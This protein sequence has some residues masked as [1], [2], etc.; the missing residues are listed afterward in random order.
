MKKIKYF[1]F[2]ILSITS[3]V[4][5]NDYLDVNENINRVHSEDIPPDLL[6]PGAASQ[7]FR[8]QAITMNGFG[9]LMMNSW[10]GNSYVYGSPFV[11]ETTLASVDNTFYNGIWD[12]LYR[13]VANF[14]AI[15]KFPNSAH[16]YDDYVAAAKVMKAFYMSTIVDMY[17]DCPYTEA[18]KYQAN[19]TPKYDNDED[20]YKSLITELETSVSLMS[21][22]N[23]SALNMEANDIIFQGNRTKWIEFANT[24]KLRMLLRMSKLTGANGT[25]RDQKL[26]TLV[27]KPFLSADVFINPGYSSA[28]D[29]Q[30]NPFYGSFVR[31]STGGKV[32]QAYIASRHISLCLNGNDD[33][34]GN[35]STE[36]VHVKFTGLIDPRRGRMFSL[37]TGGKVRGTNQGANGGQFGTPSSPTT[38][39]THG[40][41][42]TGAVGATV[43]QVVATGSARPGVLMSKA[44][45]DFIQAEIGLKY[46]TV[47]TNPDVKFKDGINASCTYLGVTT[48]NATAYQTAI[49]AKLGIGWVGTT[50]QK[51]DAILTQKWI[52][53]TSINPIQ[54]FIDYNRTGLP[55][56]PLAFNATKPNKPY[57]LMYPLSE[58]VANSANVPAITTDEL[59]NINAKSPFWLKP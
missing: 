1:A 31:N 55:V 43:A 33:G 16:K 57:R 46:P 56:T 6:F 51:L 10:S 3:L 58:Y 45:S 32:G 24:I 26:A 21:A 25:Y 49:A 37:I 34:I 42:I 50:D 28:N 5:C 48:A 19:T 38:V 27:G 40:A 15:D 17:G 9:N 53:L 54:S 29:D 20:I 14:A 35:T 13:N 59:F 4:A 39:S 23:A 44:E 12:G 52:A 36:A 2:A 30:Q 22:P 18:F 41:G 7:T 11:R 8:T 47:I